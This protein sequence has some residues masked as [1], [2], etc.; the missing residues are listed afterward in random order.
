VPVVIT[1]HEAREAD[2]TAA[3]EEIRRLEIVTGRV[4]RIRILTANPG[5]EGT[6]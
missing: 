1:T 5:E 2:V 3:L 4:V 6:P